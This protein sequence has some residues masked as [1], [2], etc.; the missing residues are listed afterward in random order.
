MLERLGRRRGGRYQS[1]RRTLR[2]HGECLQ[3]DRESGA[4]R[5]YLLL[6]PR[7]TLAWALL[8][9][10]LTHIPYNCAGLSNSDLRPL[11]QK[12]ALVHGRVHEEA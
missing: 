1:A 8:N 6:A 5:Y 2:L 7:G 10:S 11:A 4:E 9:G 12:L 3:S